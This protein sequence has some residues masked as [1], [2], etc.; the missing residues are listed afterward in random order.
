VESAACLGVQAH[1]IQ[2]E[3]DVTQG[4]PQLSIVGL[5]DASVK[6]ARERV[7]A[8]IKN[9]RLPFPAERITVNLAPADLRK[10]GSA[11]DLPIALG[12]LCAAG[13]LAPE[14]LEGYVFLGELALDGSLRAFKG[15][16][17]IV[18][19][20]SAMNQAMIIPEQNSGEASL[21]R[22]GR[23]YPAGNLR[24]VVQ[25]LTGETDILPLAVNKDTPPAAVLHSVNF[26]DIRGQSL[27]K[28]ALEIAVAG[29]HNILLIGSP[30]SGKTMMARSI[31][32][33]LPGLSF[34]EALEITK[35]HSVA[36][37]SHNIDQMIWTPPF[38]SPHHNMSAAAMTGGGS[39]PKPGEISLA[40]GGVLFLDELPEFRRDV[41]ESLRSPLEDGM[42]TVSRAKLQITYPSRFM[43]A[44][45][46]NPCPCG[47]LN[48]PKR[49]CRCS[50]AQIQKYRNRISGPIFDRIDLHVEVPP[51][52]YESMISER[53]EEASE[54]IRHRISETR[55]KQAVRYGGRPLA[56]NS[57]M[58]PDEMKLYAAPHRR[59]QKLLEAAMKE[60]Y[61]SARAYYKILKVARTIADME[62][63]EDLEEHH[64]AE[65]IQYRILD[66]QR[67]G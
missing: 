67:S 61:L 59:A 22:K 57:T 34:E 40:H 38:R 14:M 16:V 5:P 18:E 8:A 13:V 36:G 23:I 19:H 28:R 26:S 49:G 12:I 66:M 53:I 35:I 39:S 25:F 43:L 27:A 21:I 17:V 20:F 46:M 55:K 50:L 41:L 51:L 65:A 42:I 60:F 52:P 54:C 11:F 3:V 32:S 33:I 58:R 15:A 4:L 62:K 7:K 45:A 63:S 30:G 1:P 9:S 56:L 48:D 29:G 24:Q 44:A 47:F 2:I 10:E 6:E 37:Q 64:V 31:P